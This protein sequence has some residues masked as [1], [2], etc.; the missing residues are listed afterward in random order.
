[1]TW[2]WGF[3]I[4]DG[5]EA[6]F[7]GTFSDIASENSEELK[8]AARQLIEN[9]RLLLPCEVCRPHWSSHLEQH[10]LLDSDLATKTSILRWLYNARSAVA[11]RVGRP[12]EDSFEDRLE[13]WRVRR[14]DYVE[15]TLLEEQQP[16]AQSQQQ[17]HATVQSQQ[18][19]HATVQPQQQ[20][21]LHTTV[22]PQQNSVKSIPAR[23]VTNI[24][25]P[26]IA[27]ASRA[28]HPTNLQ[29]FGMNRPRSVPASSIPQHS[30]TS[31][32]PT[33]ATNVTTRPTAASRVGPTVKKKCEKCGK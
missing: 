2:A 23:L 24:V 16:I 17:H 8:R 25:T 9:W 12:L 10:P 14:A 28:G 11:N 22:Q 20:Q 1:M 26:A 13:Y 21:Q 18:Q 30:S 31:K 32:L 19:H 6:S 5:A 7:Y 4:W 3:L 29:P 27:A 33:I 15:P